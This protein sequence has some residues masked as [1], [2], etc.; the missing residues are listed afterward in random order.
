MAAP[1]RARR[2]SGI[3][4]AQ[5][6]YQPN[7]QQQPAMQV[8]QYQ[9]QPAM[10][11][12]LTGYEPLDIIGNG[13]FGIIRKVRRLS[14]D[15]LFA[16]K[17]LNFERMS[18]RDRKQIVA[19]VNILRTL[20]NDNIVKYEERFV[21]KDRGIL[22]IVM[23]YCE[24]GD[25]G[26][27]IKRYRRSDAFLQEETV[28][29]YL[30]Q[31]TRALD[32]CHYRGVP[33]DP[34][35]QPDDCSPL[36]HLVDINPNTLSEATAAA[37]A[38][39]AAAAAATAAGSP[40][41]SGLA[42]LH[43]DLK[44]ENVFLDAV[45]NIKLGDFGLSKQVGTAELARTYVGTPYYMSPELATG[46]PYDAKSDIWALGCIAYELCARKPPFDAANQAELTVKIKAGEVP[47]LPPQYSPEL[48]KVIRAMLSLNP[49][50]RPTTRQLLQVFQIQLCLRQLDVNALGRNLIFEREQLHQTQLQL[51]AAQNELQRREAALHAAPTSIAEGDRQAFAAQ[52]ADLEAREH[53]LSERLAAVEARE[54]QVSANEVDAE[55]RRAELEKKYIEWYDGER[56]RAEEVLQENREREEEMRARRESRERARA[57]ATARKSGVGS[58]NVS[59]S[60]GDRTSLRSGGA[61]RGSG[62][63]ENQG[64]SDS[65]GQDVSEERSAESLPK[66]A[67]ANVTTR[68]RRPPRASSAAR[69]TDMTAAGTGAGEMSYITSSRYMNTTTGGNLSVLPS[70]SSARN[71]RNV[72]STGSSVLP[73]RRVV[74][75][76]RASRISVVGNASVVPA[77]S[78]ASDQP[79]QTT[80]MDVDTSVFAGPGHISLVRERL[81][82][83]HPVNSPRSAL[84]ADSS[85][86]FR[87]GPRPSAAANGRPLRELLG[88]GG[89]EIVVEMEQSPGPAP[90]P[91]AARSIKASRVSRAPAGHVG[92][93][94]TLEEEEH[95][96]G[97]EAPGR[98]ASDGASDEWIDQDGFESGSSRK[99]S[100]SPTELREGA[101]GHPSPDALDVA[102]LSAGNAHRPTG[103]ASGVDLRAWRGHGDQMDLEDDSAA[104]DGD[105]NS[106]E[107][108]GVASGFDSDVAM[109]SP[110]VVKIRQAY[111][112]SLAPTTAVLGGAGPSTAQAGSGAGTANG[113]LP[114][115][116]ES[117]GSRL[118]QQLGRL[119][120]GEAQAQATKTPP[121]PSS[122]DASEG[123]D[124][125]AAVL[126]AAPVRHSRT[127]T[128]PRTDGNVTVNALA[129]GP[130]EDDLPSPF[131][132]RVSRVD[133]PATTSASGS[134]GSSSQLSSSD[135]PPSSGAGSSKILSSNANRINS[136]NGLN[137]NHGPH[138]AGSSHNLLAKAVAGSAA[139][140]QKAAEERRADERL[141][142]V[143]AENQQP[144]GAVDGIEPHSSKEQQRTSIYPA[145]PVS[146]LAPT[147]GTNVGGTAAAAERTTALQAIRARRQ[148]AAAGLVLGPSTS[149]IQGISTAGGGLAATGTGPAAGTGTARGA[150]ALSAR[151][152]AGVAR[153]MSAAAI[154]GAGAAGP[155]ATG[156]PATRVLAGGSARPAVGKTGAG[157]GAGPSRV[158]TAAASAGGPPPVPVGGANVL[159]PGVG[160]R[161]SIMHKRDG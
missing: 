137:S 22:Y 64:G 6:P 9:S 85:I 57:A 48:G 103:P 75:G 7:Q 36:A 60:V 25:L 140:A 78:S 156:A 28:W 89:D 146:S 12:A 144:G 17:E 20:E 73:T 158:S 79:N 147:S 159:I 74:S 91:A 112:R 120:L 111:R 148:S 102:A 94:P 142:R 77:S 33:A 119:H 117:P 26:S 42:I 13:T 133:S 139:A 114:V 70:S 86:R 84:R 131:I 154:G 34:L 99:A 69:V 55:K 59:S 10:P 72:P 92:T 122:G 14:D 24:G 106:R 38:A 3:P 2:L 135:N 152:S 82:S 108:E 121:M 54:A 124:R 149:L 65:V 35:P 143:G 104:T 138:R 76:P 66:Q 19:E 115:L 23:E 44:P 45:G 41:Q 43:R 21:D 132:K 1:S 88:A 47:H 4:S 116:Y 110:V 15:R 155:T 157:L 107:R 50:N 37:T 30:A 81:L 113:P 80:M 63:S 52:L 151:P 127:S 58:G 136:G 105:Q 68:S 67:D 53:A 126:G 40:H 161:R 31:M 128:G 123:Y 150:A 83:G 145:L 71:L 100:T 97:L 101:S 18:E 93:S 61:G 27:V 49:R 90:K 125:D 5:A 62:A 8:Q 118:Q 46:V 153:R 134:G 141:R 109:D 96:A 39:A 130:E 98:L 16:R 95:D 129:L 87:G 32:A 51:E 160:R 29:C 11:T 56:K